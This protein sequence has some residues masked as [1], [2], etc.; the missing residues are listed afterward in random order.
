M[1]RRWI[2]DVKGICVSKKQ[3][4][5]VEVGAPFCGA[6]ASIG[7]SVQPYKNGGKELEAMHGLNLY[8]FLARWHNP[9]DGAFTS[10]DPLCE[11]Y[12]HIS[13]YAY[14]AGNPVKYDQKGKSGSLRSNWAINGRGPVNCLDGVNPSPEGYSR[15]QKN[16]VFIHCS[17]RNGSMLP[18]DSRGKVHPVSTGCLIIVPSRKGN[19]GWDEFNSKLAGTSR[20]KMVL[21]RK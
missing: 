3:S 12:Y 6:T 20:F 2:S 11:K 19:R 13:P 10:M 7:A 1:M 8:D 16:G 21:N 15:T 17:N 14:C 4:L 5:F 18:M 9:A